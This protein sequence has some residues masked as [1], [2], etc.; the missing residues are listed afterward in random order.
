MLSSVHLVLSVDKCSSWILHADSMSGILYEHVV[1]VLQQ[2]NQS[3]ALIEANSNI[4]AHSVC[5]IKLFL[6]L[7]HW[8]FIL[9]IIVI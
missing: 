9:V 4:A 6:L 3:L 2:V 1:I 7:V 5:L 8:F